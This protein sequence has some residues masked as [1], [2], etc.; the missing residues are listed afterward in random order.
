[1]AEGMAKKAW[2]FAQSAAGSSSATPSKGR[3][4]YSTAT[5]SSVT[6]GIVCVLHTN[7]QT[8]T[9]TYIHTNKHSKHIVYMHNIH[10]AKHTHAHTH[11]H[12]HTLLD[13]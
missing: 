12:T 11:T 2:N 13:T 4:S 5:S 3:R 8:K 7:R 9:W 10:T 1:M 6:P